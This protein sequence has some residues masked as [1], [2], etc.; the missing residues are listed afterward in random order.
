MTEGGIALPP[1]QGRK[2]VKGEVIAVGP[3]PVMRNGQT[4]PVRVKVGDEVL[5]SDKA[6]EKVNKD[7]ENLIMI[8]EA[9]VAGILRPEAQ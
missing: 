5:F 8:Q 3:G 2:P 4:R 7:D 9:D 6:G 1:G